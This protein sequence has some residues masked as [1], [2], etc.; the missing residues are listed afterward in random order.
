MRP[1]RS[2]FLRLQHTQD[3]TQPF[4]A[5]MIAVAGDAFRDDYV[6]MFPGDPPAWC[7][8]FEFVH[9]MKLYAAAGIE[10]ETGEGGATAVGNKEEASA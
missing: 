10:V 6:Q 2:F 3:Y 5:R 9:R 1:V 8:Y 7:S 4:I